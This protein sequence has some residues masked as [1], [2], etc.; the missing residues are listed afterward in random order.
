MIMASM[1]EKLMELPIFKGASYSQIHSFVEKT[2]I[3]FYKLH[4]GELLCCKDDNCDKVYAILSGSVIVERSLCDDHLVMRE[5]VSSI[6][7]PGLNHLFG[8]HTTYGVNI[9]ANDQCG[10]MAFSKADLLRII[11]TDTIYLVNLLNHISM[12]SQKSELLLAEVDIC[13][14]TFL[15]RY[16]TN[17]LS[18]RNSR[19]IELIS[20]G[21]PILDLLK[22]YSVMESDILNYHISKGD[23]ILESDYKIR[24]NSAIR[25]YNP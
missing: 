14:L 1:Y 3:D 25:D 15:I 11:Q 19:D 9:V 16:F 6:F 20:V 5:N 12:L 18:S 17:I 21:M 7:M 2:H 8:F 24:L 10:V 13:N 22:S 23:I 4:P